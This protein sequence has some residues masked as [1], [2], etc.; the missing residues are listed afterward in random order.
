MT[1]FTVMDF[2]AATCSSRIELQA[3]FKGRDCFLGKGTG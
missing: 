2:S 3:G 1:T